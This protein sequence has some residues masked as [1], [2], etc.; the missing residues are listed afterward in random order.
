LKL[1]VTQDEKSKIEK[2]PTQSPEAYNLYLRGRYFWNQR[3]EAALRR[4]IAYFD[5]AVALDPTYAKAYSGIAD[6]Y[7]SLGYGIIAPREAA[8][9]AKAAALKAL[10][11]DSSLAEPH[12]SL[13]YI[14]LYYDWDFTGAEQEF[15]KAISLN[16]NYDVAYDCIGLYLTATG[17]FEDARKIIEK[18]EQIDPL[19]AFI[20]TDM[21]FN[22]YYSKNF[23]KAVQSLKSTIE[24]N[25]KFLP[26]HLW[27][28]RT[29][30]AMKKYDEAL[31]DTRWDKRS[32]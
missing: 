7:A 19:S 14:K 17:R 25:P 10:E 31:K 11:I 16:P 15:K 4:A 2:K 1:N 12:A 32:P 24:L 27:L 5:S 21:G 29:Y 3:G 22:L 6:C 26:A 18:A 9:K 8:P 23:D 30:Q 13:G 20:S 28:S